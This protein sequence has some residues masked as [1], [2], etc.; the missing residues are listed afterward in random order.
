MDGS[1]QKLIFI[2]LCWE[3]YSAL[4]CYIH[5]HQ[6]ELQQKSSFLLK[7]Q[8]AGEECLFKEPPKD[9]PSLLWAALSVLGDSRL[10]PTGL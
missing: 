1:R 5:P 2:H 10:S 3:I 7:E 4:H 9:P 8:N 6:Q